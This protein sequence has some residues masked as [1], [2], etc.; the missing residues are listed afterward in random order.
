MVHLVCSDVFYAYNLGF[1]LTVIIVNYRLPVSLAK[2][3]KVVLINCEYDDG[4]GH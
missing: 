2:H 1:V 4:V 3:Y